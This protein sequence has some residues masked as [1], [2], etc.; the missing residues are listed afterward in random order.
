MLLGRTLRYLRASYKDKRYINLTNK[1]LHVPCAERFA[2]FLSD[3]TDFQFVAN[4]AD[5]L[6]TRCPR[7]S[8]IAVRSAI[9]FQSAVDE[10]SFGQPSLFEEIVKS[11]VQAQR[12]IWQ[13]GDRG[14]LNFALLIVL[15]F[16]P[17]NVDF[18]VFE[19]DIALL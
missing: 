8:F 13:C 3:A 14:Y 12:M 10:L 16:P 7:D 15:S 5:V 1:I 4:F 9:P 2:H 19:L 17:K 6:V 11:V 18:S